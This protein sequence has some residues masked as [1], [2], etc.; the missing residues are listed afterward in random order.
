[1]TTTFALKESCIDHFLFKYQW[2][3][4]SRDSVIGNLVIGDFKHAFDAFLMF[5]KFDF[6][7]GDLFIVVYIILQMITFWMQIGNISDIPGI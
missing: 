3:R 7:W 6:L 1:M 5:Q 2:P 4:C